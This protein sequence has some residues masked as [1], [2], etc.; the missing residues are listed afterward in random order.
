MSNLAIV[1]S[2]CAGID[3]AFARDAGLA[4]RFPEPRPL[5]A[6]PTS[7]LKSFVTDRLGHDRRYA[8]DCSKIERELGYRAQIGDFVEGF[9]TTLGW[10]LGNQDWWLN[11]KQA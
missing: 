6:F 9:S 1:E 5:A 4:E 7:S 3:D 10:Y 2:I 8:I 11:F